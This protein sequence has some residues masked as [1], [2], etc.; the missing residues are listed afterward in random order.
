MITT[1]F[2]ANADQLNSRHKYI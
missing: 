1:V 2:S